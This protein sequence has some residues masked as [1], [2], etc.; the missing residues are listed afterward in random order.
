MSRSRELAAAVGLCLLGAAL[1]LLALSRPWLTLRLGAAPPLPSRRVDIRGAHLVPGARALGLLGL[2]GVAALPA[3]RRLGRVLV[4]LLLVGAGAGVVADIARALA[5]PRAA[6]VRSGSPAQDG[7]GL[8][9][10]PW[11]AIAGAVLIG[12][13]GLLAVV[14]GR[15]WSELSARYDAPS[16]PRPQREPSLWEQLDRGEDPTSAGSAGAD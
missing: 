4:G 6:L 10:W 5:D 14:R 9:V 11:V 15:R 3:T 16:A 7:A 1:V 2:A 12:A 8:G 13:A